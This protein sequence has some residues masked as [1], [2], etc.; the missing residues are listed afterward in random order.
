MQGRIWSVTALVLSVG[1][2]ACGGSNSNNNPSSDPTTPAEKTTIKVPNSANPAF[3]FDISYTDSGKYYLA[4]RN[5]AS[6]DVVDTHTNALIGQIKGGFTG[7][8]KTTDTSGPDGLVGIPGTSTLYAGDVNN[9]KVI[10]TA[11]Q[12]VVGTIAVSDAGERVDE[13]CYD[14]DDDIV[15]FASPGDTPP[16]TT[17]ISNKTRTIMSKL[18]FPTSSGLEACVY[19][20]RTKSFLINNDGTPANPE[21][22]VDVI[23]AASV[24]AG[25]PG[26]SSVYPL[27]NCSPAGLALGPDNDMLVGCDQPEGQKLT[28][29]ILDRTTGSTLATLPFGGVDQVT[30]DPV[31]NRYFLP[32]RHETANGVAA[33]SGYT[34]LLGVVDGASRKVI[35]QIPTGNGVHSVAVDGATNQVYVPFQPGATNFPIGGILVYNAH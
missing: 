5:N 9:I 13:G 4:D 20:P 29:L 6:V 31:S 15:M 19:D 17:F 22:E 2:A 24:V 11:A 8:G 30:Y 14:P 10:D 1:L 23:P 7:I 12:Q 34:P 26:V 16:F 18:T 3:S 28:S 25:T 35:D 27:G 32:A 21:G 33:S